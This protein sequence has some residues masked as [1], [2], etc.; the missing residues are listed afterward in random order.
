[1]GEGTARGAKNG[2]VAGGTRHPSRREG[3]KNNFFLR[4]DGGGGLRLVQI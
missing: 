3:R 4:R 1:M 2:E